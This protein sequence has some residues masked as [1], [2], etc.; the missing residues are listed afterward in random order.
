[1][2]ELADILDDL[3][4]AKE[5]KGLTYQDIADQTE[6]NGEAVSVTSIRRVLAKDADPNA[7]RL[8]QTIIPIARVLLDDV[9]NLFVD[10]KEPGEIEILRQDI[11]YQVDTYLSDIIEERR[12]AYRWYRKYIKAIFILVVISLLLDCAFRSI[13]FIRY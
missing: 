7:F 4:T 8:K 12:T 1:M 10:E 13:G 6:R 11:Q 5:E 3:R 9:D 2:K